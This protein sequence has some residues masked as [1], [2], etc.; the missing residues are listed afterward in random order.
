MP[1]PTLVG[2]RGRATSL[3]AVGALAGAA[4]ALPAATTAAGAPATGAATATVAI[5]A[6]G[7]APR[8]Y[9]PPAGVRFNKPLGS[10]AARR[11][12]LDHLIRT[13]DSV[14]GG[15]RIHFASWN[16]R[17]DAM[18]DALV[19]AH[20]RGVTVRVVVDRLNANP[21][22]PNR[23]VNRLDTALD[24]N[25]ARPPE[26]RSGLVRCRSAC[27]GRTGI[28]HTKF[29]LFSRAAAARA[30]AMVGSANATDL[31]ATHQWND[32]YTVKNRQPVYDEFVRVFDEMYRDRRSPQPY[33]SSTY[34]GLT[35]YFYPYAGAGATGDPVLNELGRTTCR[36]A[37]GGA[38]TNGRTQLRIAMTSWHGQR[39][40]AIAR[41]VREMFNRGCDVK[42]V[43]AVMGNEVLRILRR[44]GARPVPLRQIVQDLNRDGV[45]DRYLHM[46][47]LAISGVYRGR[48]DAQVTF[49]G[50]ANW[51]PVALVSDEA[52]LRVDSAGIRSRYA[53]WVN[54][55][56]ANPPYNPGSRVGT[57][58]TAGR[59]TATYPGDP[60]TALP[61]AEVERIARARGVDPYARI[62]RG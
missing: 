24:G 47:A 50:S 7:N 20:R 62:P 42:I 11:A 49:N 60:A 39:G 51:T 21:D 32:L 13:T 54:T 3:L 57:A 33:V 44:G 14:P 6:V 53:R 16:I 46:K 8:S 15:E 29:F 52:G 1:R 28:A 43:Y 12:I 35:T 18:V 58:S 4:L 23:G 31:S 55:L 19:R 26:A 17:S 2:L 37:T 25:G 9:D 10:R 61:P 27:R 22:N 34:G 56:Y 38:G 59:L 48:T 40:I 5:A 41:R 30:V 36:G 45:Y